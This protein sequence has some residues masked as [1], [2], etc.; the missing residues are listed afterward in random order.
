MKYKISIE[1]QKDIENI[2]LYTF[3]TWSV[4][5]ADRYYNLIL[6]EIEYIALHPNAGKDYSHVRKGYYR[7]EIKSH[8]IF[9]KINLQV[10][11]IIRILHQQMDIQ[12]RLNE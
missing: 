7:S 3:E 4:E 2:W 12:N 8:F 10:V 5:Q 6:D 11:E 9:Y 1:A